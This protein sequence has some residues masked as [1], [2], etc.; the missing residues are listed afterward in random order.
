MTEISTYATYY[1]GAVFALA[2]V[3]IGLDVRSTR[4]AQQKL[5]ADCFRNDPEAADNLVALPP[6]KV[7]EL[8]GTS[9]K[10]VR[11]MIAKSLNEWV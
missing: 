2:L 11:K 5:I 1:F 8:L 7:A 4:A 10:H 9:P 6:E 3:L